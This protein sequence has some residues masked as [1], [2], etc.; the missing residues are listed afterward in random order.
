[1]VSNYTDQNF[2]TSNINVATDDIGSLIRRGILSGHYRNGQVLTQAELAQEFGVSRLIVHRSLARLKEDGVLITKRR[3]G[4]AVQLTRR[5]FGKPEDLRVLLLSA[6]IYHPFFPRFFESLENR[7][8]KHGALVILVNESARQGR[9]QRVTVDI[10][11]FGRLQDSGVHDAVLWPFYGGSDEERLLRL[12]GIGWNIVLFDHFSNGGSADCV[13]LDNHHA[14]DA[15]M[16]DLRRQGC[17]RVQYLGWTHE[18]VPLGSTEERARAFEQC[19]AGFT[20]TSF[21]LDRDKGQYRIEIRAIVQRLMDERQMP[22][23]FVCVNGEVAEGL[24]EVLCSCEESP[25][26]AVVDEL[27]A[28]LD[29]QVLSIR[30]PVEQMAS[31]VF[32]CLLKQRADGQAWKAQILRMRGVLVGCSSPG[33]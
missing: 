25:L 4:T 20:T 29:I 6:P 24:L 7:A 19:S 16:A 17:R 21:E 26:V 23:A 14:I 2:R 8:A 22:D 10:E 27:R 12:R 5:G 9:R 13:G 32:D 15:L 18:S 1:M 3:V 30:Q 31:V 28:P 33:S 11:T